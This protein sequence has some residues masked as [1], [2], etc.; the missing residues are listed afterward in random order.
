VSRE[1]AFPALPPDVLARA[2]AVRERRMPGGGQCQR[3]VP[4]QDELTVRELE[5][6]D[7]VAVGDSNAEIAEKLHIGQQTVMSHVKHLLF[8]LGAR[9]RAHAVACGFRTGLF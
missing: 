2:D 1:T 4:R 5:V 7:L 6:L 9:N 3:T 8:K